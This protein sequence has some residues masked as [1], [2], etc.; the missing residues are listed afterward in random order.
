MAMDWATYFGLI[1]N[2]FTLPFGNDMFAGIALML[3]MIVLMGAMGLGLDASIVIG[4]GF[5]LVMSVTLLTIDLTG[6]IVIVL[7]VLV[8][9]AALRL[10][11]K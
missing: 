8:A 4:G 11:R 7:A 2:V 3:G 5:F 10:F 9:L 6:I 1:A